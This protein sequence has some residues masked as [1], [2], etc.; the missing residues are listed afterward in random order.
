MGAIAPLEQF[1]QLP[2]NFLVLLAD[3][4]DIRM[5][6]GQDPLKH[7]LGIGQTRWRGSRCSSS[8]GTDAL[9]PP[10]LKVATV[11][12]LLIVVAVSAYYL[13]ARQATELNSMIALRYR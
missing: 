3:T 2:S 11:S 12:F 1:H 8:W 9:H 10:A 7:F 4:F 5:W 6:L 13:P